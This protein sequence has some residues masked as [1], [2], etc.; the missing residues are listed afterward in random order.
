MRAIGAISLA[1]AALSLAGAALASPAAAQDAAD[2]YALSPE[3]LLDATVISVSRSPESQWD[4]AAAVFVI[5]GEDISRS[6]ATSIAEALRLAPGVQVARI[7]TGGWAVSVRGFNAAL[8]NKLLVLIDGREVYDPLFSGVYWDVQDTALEDVARIEIIRGPGASLWGANAVNGVINIITKRAED[9]HGLLVSAAAGN[10]ERGLASVRYGGQSGRA[11]WRVYGRGFER[12]SFRTLSGADANGNWRSWRG[13]FRVD[14]DGAGRDS[15]TVQGEAY[16][17]DKGQLRSVPQLVAPYGVL[18]AEDVRASGGNLLARW[19]R[20][21]DNDARLMVQTYLDITSRDQI[22]LQDERGT[23]DLEVQYNLPHIG[24]HALVTGARYRSTR[25]DLDY[26]SIILG[27]DPTLEEQ[28]SSA[29]VQDTIT[30]APGRWALILG[31]KFD[32]NDFTGF[33]AQPNARLQWLGGERES[34]WASVSR[35]VR[36]P[37]AL[38]RE[39]RVRTGVIPPGLFAV[40]VSVETIPSPGFESEELL[41]FELGYRRR[42]SDDFVTDF[43]AFHNEYDGLATLSLLAPEIGMNPLHLILPI[44]H[45]NLTD[46]HADGFEAVLDWRASGQIGVQATYSFLELELHGPPPAFA[47]NAEAAQTTSPRN[48]ANVRVQWDGGG[49]WSGDAVVYYMDSIPG[50]AVAPSVRMDARLGWR[51]SEHATFELVGSNLFDDSRPEF[52]N[53]ASTVAIERSIFGR[54]TWRG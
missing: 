3:Q 40:P 7:Q 44:G 24:R 20:H 16:R 33:E 25:V 51:L 36:T 5:S 13:G 6:G 48:M 49:R 30:L 10:V 41:A 37:S 46:A 18:T 28:L 14:I 19:T 31:S 32:Q 21:F 45:T 29:F 12:A 11:H 1:G 2:P 50:L 38:E 15:F 35:A 43:A 34:A 27:A 26:T 47:I 22:P 8:A 9:T 42:W 39:M 17:S 4:A 53:D 52:G 54:L 23:F